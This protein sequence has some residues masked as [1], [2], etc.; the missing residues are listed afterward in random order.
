M[1][2]KIFMLLAFAGHVLCGITDCLMAYTPDGRFE[3]SIMKDNQKMSDVFRNMPLKNLIMAMLLGVVALTMTAFGYFGLCNW[4]GQFSKG[5]AW[6]MF[7]AI[8]LY[9]MFC[10]AHHVLC[11]TVEWFYVRMGRSEEALGTVMEF[12]KKTSPTMYVC[13][14]GLLLFA[15]TFL[16]AVASGKTDLPRW[17][18]LF[19]TLPLFLVLSPTRAPAKGN[20]AGAVMFLGLLFLI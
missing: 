2:L 20:I 10:V 18:C 12:F 5:F 11:G 15:V 14:L 16:I 9:L 13:Y 4:M 7:V 19:N 17:A 3:F 8:V 1:T 6:G